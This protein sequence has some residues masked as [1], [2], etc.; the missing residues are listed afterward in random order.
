MANYLQSPTFLYN[1]ATVIELGRHIEI[2]LLTND[3]VAVPGLGGFVAHS[4]PAKYDNDFYVPPMRTLGF[5][6]SIKLNDSLLAQSYVEAYDISYPEALRRIADDV[7]QI[8]AILDNEGTYEFR[9]LGQL[10]K[11]NSNTL[12]FSPD[13]RGLMT[14]HLYGLVSVPV[15]ISGK[16]KGKEK[17][18]EDGYVKIKVAWLRNTAAVAAIVL[19]A[20]LITKPIA[21][22]NPMMSLSNIDSSIL[23]FLMPKTVEKGEPTVDIA[24]PVEEDSMAIVEVTK[25]DTI[26]IDNDKYTL[27]LASRITQKNADAYASVIREN[28]HEDVYTF[29][30]NGILRV[31]YGSYPTETEAYNALRHLSSS[32]FFKEAWV[33]KK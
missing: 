16:V 19:L 22:K 28:G 21:N 10:S 5:N 3:C 9:G 25:P 24:K 31:G 6:Q 29:E 17:E 13:E 26:A 4:I 14:P 15:A 12:L 20:L 8:N 33:F 11:T 32:R 1:F 18:E 2:L 27:I 7:E 23:T 30:K